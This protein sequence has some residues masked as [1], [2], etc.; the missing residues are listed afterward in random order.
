MIPPVYDLLHASSAVVAIVADRIGA[1]GQVIPTEVRP[2]I[3]WQLVS[4]T[5]DNTLD[6]GRAPNDRASVQ[7]D[8]YHKTEAGLRSLV[9]AARSALES[10]G[11][12]VGLMVDERDAETQ[13][14]RMALQFDFIVTP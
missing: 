13:L 14:F 3:T 2:Y 12:Y 10:D 5:G 8:C 9:N 7:L 11:Y 6:R 1:H 4:G